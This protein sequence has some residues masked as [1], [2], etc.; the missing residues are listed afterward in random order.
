MT[1]NG[2]F[3]LYYIIHMSY[4]AHVHTNLNEDRYILLEQTLDQAP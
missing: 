1:L 2:N 4:G 3:A